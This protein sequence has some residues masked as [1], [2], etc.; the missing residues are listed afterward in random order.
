M[1]LLQPTEGEVL[2][3]GQRIQHIGLQNFRRQIGTV[4][5][6][7]VLLTGSLAA[8]QVLGG[9]APVQVRAQ[10]ERHRARLA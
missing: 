3:G 4:M 10:I 6:E 2:Y 1:G 7:D 9:T 5:Q 8:R